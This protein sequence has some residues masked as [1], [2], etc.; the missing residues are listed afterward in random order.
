MTFGLPTPDADVHV[1][2]VHDVSAPADAR[3]AMAPISGSGAF[4]DDVQMVTAELVANVVRHTE[5]GGALLAW[6]GDPVRL[7]VHDTSSVLPHIERARRSGGLGLWIV[8]TLCSRWGSRLEE[9]GKVVWAEF[10]QDSADQFRSDVAFFD[11]VAH[12][13]RNPREFDVDVD[14]HVREAALHARELLAAAVAAAATARVDEVR[15]LL[16]AADERDALADARDAA[17][18]VREHAASRDSFA[19]PGDEFFAVLEARRAAAIGRAESKHDRELSA[20]DRARLAN[21]G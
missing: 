5:F 10:D 20:G 13:R 1:L 17:A 15:R 18:E 7:E 2:I 14:I 6:D 21:E 12:Y 11:L 19:E 3:L 8:D 4:F 16:S 9:T